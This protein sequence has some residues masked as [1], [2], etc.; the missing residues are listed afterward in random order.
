MGIK[1]IEEKSKIIHNTEVKLFCEF[2]N[3]SSDKLMLNINVL[4]PKVLYAKNKA[5]AS[6]TTYPMNNKTLAHVGGS[7]LSEVAINRG[8][9]PTK[10]IKAIDVIL[11]IKFV[12]ADVVKLLNKKIILTKAR[13]P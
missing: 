11:K 2:L 12:S 3:A 10:Q 9:V 8:N 5:P 13:T 7:I 1:A 6:K 4:S